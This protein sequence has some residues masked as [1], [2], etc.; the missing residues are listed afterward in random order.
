MDTTALSTM[1]AV[2]VASA[3]AN[4]RRF[5]FS[6]RRSK[7]VPLR[8]G[9]ASANTTEVDHAVKPRTDPDGPFLL[10]KRHQRYRSWAV[11]M[12]TSS[13]ELSDKR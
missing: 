4:S 6:P 13:F 2:R 7:K 10:K 1:G 8:C 9:V 12:A 5:D 11:F 3:V